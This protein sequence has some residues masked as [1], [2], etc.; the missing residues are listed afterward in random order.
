MP[1]RE[2]KRVVVVIALVSVMWTGCTT[3]EPVPPMSP[4]ASAWASLRA[5][6]TLESSID[7]LR[8]RVMLLEQAVEGLGAWRITIDIVIAD[9]LGDAL[10]ASVQLDLL[11]E[12]LEGQSARFEELQTSFAASQDAAATPGA[13]QL[14]DAGGNL[15]GQLLD[16]QV[17]DNCEGIGSAGTEKCSRYIFYC[18]SLGLLASVQDHHGGFPGTTYFEFP[19]CEGQCYLDEAYGYLKQ[20]FRYLGGQL[21]VADP[22]APQSSIDWLSY[23]TEIGEC[24]NGSGTHDYV[25]PGVVVQSPPFPVPLQL[26]FHVE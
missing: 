1:S 15:M 2:R 23:R 22:E 4:P 9:L 16:A 12:L 5:S 11:A 20:P 10:E 3:S 24:V 18:A 19:D 14:Y 26:P 17:P 13:L 7:A 8:V 6:M 21:Y 25:R